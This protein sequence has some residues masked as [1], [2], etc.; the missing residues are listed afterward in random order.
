[1]FK[2]VMIAAAAVAVLSSG[3][4]ALE[5]K[6]LIGDV[7]V[8]RGGSQVAPLSI[9][10]KIQQN[11]RIVTGKQGAVTL[12]YA[13]GSEIRIQE[14]TTLTIG[15]MPGGSDSAPVSVISGVVITQFAKLSKGQDARRSVYTPTTVCA[16]RGTQFTVAVS[17]GADSRV[18]L[19]EGSLDVHNPYGG[20][21]IEAGQNIETGIA[22]APAAA[23]SSVPIDQWKSAQ[24]EKLSSTAPDKGSQFSAYMNDFSQRGSKSSKAIDGI[25]EKV[26]DAKDGKTIDASGKE[27]DSVA[28]SVEEDMYL[29]SAASSSI[30]AIT[31]RFKNDKNAMYQKFLKLKE[32]SNKVKEQ[33]QRNYEA[34]QAVKES[35]KKAKDA[36]LNRQKEDAYKIKAG[37]NL[38]NVKPQIDKKSTE[39]K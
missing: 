4:Q 25:G 27:L 34:I 21:K 11:D 7:T 3:A 38:Q 26:K 10:T 17:D 19:S 39:Q 23:E 15:K 2:K 30:E 37:V 28:A 13:D 9:G 20:Q 35:Y 33:L 24:D 6:F 29:S 14:K 32:D 22:Q 12:S 31:D 1:M 16:V 36:I 18:E 5:I 8:S